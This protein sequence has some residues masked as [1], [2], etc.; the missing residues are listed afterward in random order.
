MK[1]GNYTRE[2]ANDLENGK[3]SLHGTGNKTRFRADYGRSKREFT[4]LKNGGP[5]S[6]VQSE[7]RPGKNN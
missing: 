6:V 5:M 4:F 2:V 7:F 1:L 3:R